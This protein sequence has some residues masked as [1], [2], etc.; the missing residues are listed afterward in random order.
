MTKLTNKIILVTGGSTGIGLA[1][2]QAFASEGARVFLTGRRQ[3]ELDAA[4]ATIP[5]ATG[6]AGDTANAADLDRL[7]A[8]IKRDAGRLDVVYANAGGGDMLPLGE[9]TEAHYASIFD[10]NVKGVLFTVQGALPLMTAGGSIILAGSTTGSK[11]TA[12]FSVYSASKAAVRNF[13][14]S[15]TAELAPRGIRV[16]TL[17]PG[18]VKTPGLLGLAPDES[19]HA[20]LLAQLASGVPMGRVA[21]PLEIARVAVFLAS[22]DSSYVTG[23]ELFVDGGAAQV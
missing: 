14:R 1:A 5:G 17:S 6:I 9:I 3:A 21:E 19:A 15:W 18:P 12:A 20:G 11:G 22:E 7:F 10:R 13:A 2:A 16:N 23:T 8:Q 4:V